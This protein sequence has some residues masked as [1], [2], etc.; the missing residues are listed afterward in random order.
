MRHHPV[1]YLLAVCW[2]AVIFLDIP[3]VVAL[4]HRLTVFGTDS[5]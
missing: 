4:T 3:A 2:L 5:I 1:E